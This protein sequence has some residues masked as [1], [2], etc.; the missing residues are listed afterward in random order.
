MI[1]LLTNLVP[2]PYRVAALVAFAGALWLHGWWTGK[3]GVEREMDIKDARIDAVSDQAAVDRA[4]LKRERDENTKRTKEDHDA[5]VADIHAYYAA[6]PPDRV[7][8]IVWAGS[9]CPPGNPAADRPGGTPPG[10][11][12]SVAAGPNQFEFEKNCALDAAQVNA[13]RQFLIRNKFPVE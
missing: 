7:R 12:E 5:E 8:I 6:V 11:A 13:L 10:A 2:W 4:R 9:S 3:E 1:S